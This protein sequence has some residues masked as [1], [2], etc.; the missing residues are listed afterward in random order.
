ME[1]SQTFQLP[2]RIENL[3][4]PL[5]ALQTR[6]RLAQPVDNAIAQ[7]N[8]RVQSKRPADHGSRP[9]NASAVAD[10]FNGFQQSRQPY[11]L[12]HAFHQTQYIILHSPLRG[13]FRC[14]N[15]LVTETQAELPTV[16]HR[17][18]LAKFLR[19]QAGSVVNA[20]QCIRRMDGDDRVCSGLEQFLV[21]FLERTD[22]W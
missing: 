10:V 18:A 15:N 22:R 19:S 12:A 1:Y 6:A 7:S 17:H 5:D 21:A 14:Q 2:P 13:C 9:G 4:Q 11:A 20:A 16:Q 8:Q 3:D